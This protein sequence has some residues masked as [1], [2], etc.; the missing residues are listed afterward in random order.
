MACR[1]A[2][3]GG[4]GQRPSVETE[5][6]YEH[7]RQFIDSAAHQLRTP[8]AALNLQAQLI[9]EEDD[10]LERAIQVRQLREASR[11]PAI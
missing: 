1:P 6:S 4:V 8:L 10:P 3:A 11:G 2:A 7:E 5:R 9:A